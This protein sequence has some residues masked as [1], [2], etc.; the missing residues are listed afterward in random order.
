MELAK[1]ASFFNMSDMIDLEVCERCW[2]STSLGPVLA[3]CIVSKGEEIDS[4]R[5]DEKVQHAINCPAAP[6]RLDR[7]IGKNINLNTTLL[8]SLL[9]FSKDGESLT[10]EDLAEHH[11]LRHN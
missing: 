4:S 3:R 10:L 11:L 2:P 5:Q 7:D 1:G 8:E 9:G 6:T